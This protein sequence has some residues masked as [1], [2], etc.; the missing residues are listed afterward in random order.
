MTITSST[1]AQVNAALRKQS[2]AADVKA[3]EKNDAKAKA[4]AAEAPAVVVKTTSQPVQASAAA[5]SGTA[6]ETAEDALKEA[7]AFSSALA[8]QNSSIANA[9][10]S[11]VA[12]L[13][14]EF[15]AAYA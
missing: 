9:S 3:S 12:G 15:E 14:S 7:K 4:S 13:L 2:Q 11:T 6:L 10:P 5:V 8:Q 1:E